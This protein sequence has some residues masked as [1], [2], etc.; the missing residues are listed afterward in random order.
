MVWKPPYYFID[1]PY[2]GYIITMQ[3]P[4]DIKRPYS[5]SVDTKEHNVSIRDAKSQEIVTEQFIR[6]D[7]N[8]INPTA[9][10]L[11]MIMEVISITL[12][13]KEEEM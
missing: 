10:N 2:M 6:T 1:I 5:M 7:D 8:P 13:K 12:A 9:F 3:I 11:E 4:D